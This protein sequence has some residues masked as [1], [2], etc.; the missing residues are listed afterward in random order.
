MSFI[1]II[2]TQIGHVI[3]VANLNIFVAAI[4]CKTCV[5]SA[6]PLV[7]VAKMAGKAN[8]I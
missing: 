4:C 5:H 1:T 6:L 7:K 8:C 3:A 2:G